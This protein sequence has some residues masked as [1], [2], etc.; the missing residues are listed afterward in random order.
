[1]GFYNKLG[2]TAGEVCSRPF[3]GTGAFYFIERW[4]FMI[5]KSTRSSKEKILSSEA[6][7][8]GIAKDGGLYVPDE[9]PKI[10]ERLET[11]LNMTYQELALFLMEKYFTDF[12][13]HELKNCIEKA[14]DYKFENKNIVPLV[15]K[16]GVHFLELFHGPTLAFKDIA[17]T[18]LPHLMKTAI[19]KEGMEKEVVILTATSGDTGKAA[20]EGF[21]GVEGTKIIVFFPENGVSVIQKRQM[22]TQEGRNTFVASIQG[23]FD[24]AQSG[25]KKL[26]NDSE[27]EELLN[28]NNFM[29]S[30]AN[31]IN[32]G[33]LVPQIVYYF[34]GYLTLLRSGKIIKGQVINVAVPT[35]NF[36]NILAAYYSKRMG[37][38]INRLICASNENNVLCDFFNTGVYDS[39]REL[40]L[41]NSPSMDILVSSNL[42]RLLYEVSGRDEKLI[43]ELMRKLQTDGRYEVAETMFEEIK[44]FHGGFTSEEEALKSIRKLYEVSGYVMDTHTAVAYSVYEKY[45]AKTGD[46]TETII[47][48]T[49]SPFKFAESVLNAIGIESDGLGDFETIKQLANTAGIEMP[50]AI[51][52]LE[53]KEILHKNFYKKNEIKLAVQ[54]FLKL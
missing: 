22:L 32:I 4:Y 54:K 38:P 9:I 33:R 10:E 30:S 41:T 27:F 45:R 40:K 25:V 2:G 21:A 51:V 49:A 23:N 35:G 44:Q 53:T 13:T 24:D 36:G 16:E 14:Y 19:N 42:E 6:V 43:E 52:A 20:L 12:Q 31:S 29:L 26:F 3:L 17:L 8:R 5:Y 47:A 15:E 1:V 37:L 18:I 11:L 7:I 46:T 28:Q 48:A 50:K 39:R 34:Y